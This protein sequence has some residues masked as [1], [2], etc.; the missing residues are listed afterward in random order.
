M[1][2]S[3]GKNC[4]QLQKQLDDLKNSSQNCSTQK[5]CN[6]ENSIANLIKN[7]NLNI[8]NQTLQS[9]NEKHSK[10]QESARF[11]K[12]TFEKRIQQ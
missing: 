7:N 2:R 11:Q 8:F 10:R 4:S 1:Q 5:I 12:T 9:S 6:K 3:T